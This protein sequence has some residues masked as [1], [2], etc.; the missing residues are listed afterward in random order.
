MAVGKMS[1]DYPFYTK[2]LGAREQNTE[3]W[4]PPTTLAASHCYLTRPPLAETTIQWTWLIVVCRGTGWG[5][6]R[7]PWD[8]GS[9]HG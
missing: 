6:P 9:R 4:R 5:A 7:R 1:S 8:D 2:L 3:R